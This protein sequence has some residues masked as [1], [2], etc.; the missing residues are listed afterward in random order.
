MEIRYLSALILSLRVTKQKWLLAF[1]RVFF[2][3]E[4][5]VL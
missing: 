5:W 4:Q 1:H 3:I 2:G